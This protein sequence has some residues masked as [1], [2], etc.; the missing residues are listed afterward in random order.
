MTVLV[1]TRPLDPTADLV[2]HELHRSGTPVLRCDPGD[3]PGTLELEARISTTGAVTGTLRTQEREVD[4]AEIRSVYHRRPTSPRSHPALDERDRLWSEREA[5]AG[6]NGVL[7][8][9]NCRW[10]NR[11]RHNTAA[12]R[13]PRQLVAAARVGLSVPESLVTNTV[14]AA[15]EFAATART[16]VYKSMTGG[17]TPGEALERAE[18][19]YTTIVTADELTP[20]V[21]HTA[22]LFQVWVDKAYEV[23]VTVA[24]EM[25]FAVRIDAASPTARIDWRADY[26]HLSYLPVEPPAE[27]SKAVRKLMRE[28]HLT[29][30]ALDFVVT[31]DGRWVFLELNPN[32]QWGW[33]QLATG[34]P[35]AEAIADNLRESSL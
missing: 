34:L 21:G 6:L 35:I 20:G 17:P 7:D 14:E 26:R 3:F 4:L 18:A 24:G 32:G 12:E 16:M 25:V 9:L 10:I 28:L 23:R 2:I 15:R 30:G 27:V 8:A 1:L 29:F 11:P 22:H 5:G 19:L 13:K 31:P 33:I